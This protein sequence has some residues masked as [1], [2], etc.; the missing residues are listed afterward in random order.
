MSKYKNDIVD[1]LG[2]PIRGCELCVNF[3]YYDDSDPDYDKSQDGFACL[4]K[5]VSNFK[6]FPCISK[7]ECFEFDEYRDYSS[8][9]TGYR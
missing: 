1:D 5:D 4:L 7:L 9:P 2:I 3:T 8:S 6:T